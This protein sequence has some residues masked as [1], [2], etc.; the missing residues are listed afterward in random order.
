MIDLEM[1]YKDLL[2]KDG[3]EYDE[4]QFNAVEILNSFRKFGL[5]IIARNPK[6]IYE[7]INEI[8]T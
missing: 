1:I 4:S 3:L 8:S 2:K 7:V 6:N 5:A